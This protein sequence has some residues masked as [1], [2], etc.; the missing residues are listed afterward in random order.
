VLCAPTAGSGTLLGGVEDLGVL[1]PLDG[2]ETLGYAS[3]RYS[4]AGDSFS[5]RFEGE[6]ISKYACTTQE[7]V[8]RKGAIVVGDPPAPNELPPMVERG[9]WGVLG[10]AVLS[11]LAAGEYLRRQ[12]ATGG[13]DVPA[14]PR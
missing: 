2:D 6:G 12:R 9:V 14:A 3:P 8:G 4:E 11:P 5:R 1:G 13:R 7:D 10:L